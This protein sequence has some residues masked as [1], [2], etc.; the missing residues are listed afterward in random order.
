VDSGSGARLGYATREVVKDNRRPSSAG[1]RSS[2]GRRLFF[3]GRTMSTR[4][5]Q[6]PRGETLY[7]RCSLQVEA[8]VWV[9]YQVC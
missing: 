3:C 9:S 8:A 2:L 6:K 4:H 1:L 5:T 7:N